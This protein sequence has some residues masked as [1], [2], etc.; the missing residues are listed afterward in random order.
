MNEVIVVGSKQ[1]LIGNGYVYENIGKEFSSYRTIRSLIG[2]LVN[3][4][5]RISFS[6][7]I[8]DTQAGLKGFTKIK[9]FSNFIFFSKR[10]FFDLEL[11]LLYI[12]KKKKIFS[13]PVSFKVP[14]D[15]SIKILDL[16]KN[17]EV[18]KELII[19][20]LKKNK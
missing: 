5:I 3:L 16:K 20:C 8:R 12:S 13:I 11:L 4:I 15:S 6:I 10:F 7:K 1:E 19:I 18:I 17:F 14:I 9:N 2:Y